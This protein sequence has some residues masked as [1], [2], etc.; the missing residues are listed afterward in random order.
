[1]LWNNDCR[2]ARESMNLMVDPR[3]IKPRDLMTAGYLN[4]LFTEVQGKQRTDS[5]YPVRERILNTTPN[6]IL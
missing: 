3:G 4:H 5:Q 1:M 2:F 6:S